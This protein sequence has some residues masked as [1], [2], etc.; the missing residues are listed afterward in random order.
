MVLSL[1]VRHVVY[2]LLHVA[3][4]QGD[5]VFC[6]P[7]ATEEGPFGAETFCYVKQSIYHVSYAQRKNHQYLYIDV[8]MNLYSFKN[9]TV[10]EFV[11]IGALG[12]VRVQTSML[13]HAC[14]YPCT[15]TCMHTY[16]R[17][18]ST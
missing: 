10:I 12:C 11:H 4:R 5:G 9:C 14:M 13:T 17:H 2:R 6:T 7:F 1:S 18:M 16:W 15:H 8:V 3:K